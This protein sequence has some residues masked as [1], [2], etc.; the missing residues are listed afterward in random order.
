VGWGEEEMYANLATA[1]L[2]LYIPSERS[3]TDKDNVLLAFPSVCL[4]A[5]YK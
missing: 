1:G 5:V 3:E 4:C 2:F